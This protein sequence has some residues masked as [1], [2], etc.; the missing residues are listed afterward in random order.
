VL[1]PNKL[2]KKVRKKKEPEKE[3]PHEMSE[4]ELYA[5][6]KRRLNK[7]FI[8][9]L[10][11]DKLKMKITTESNNAT[12]VTTTTT[13]INT[14]NTNQ[15]FNEVMEHTGKGNHRHDFSDAITETTN[16]GGS[17]QE[18]TTNYKDESNWTIDFF[19][20]HT[21]KKFSI[22]T[23]R[24]KTPYNG[25]VLLAR[26]KDFSPA[27]DT[28]EPLHHAAQHHKAQV[29]SYVKR[30]ENVEL[31]QHIQENKMNLFTA[32]IAQEICKDIMTENKSKNT[33]I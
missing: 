2:T 14:P 1:Q 21:K 29:L 11:L 17:E 32:D 15:E 18:V 19:V 25:Y 12:M 6:E 20:N 3:Q 26:W 30:P 13:S 7:E 9:R 8:K 24:K 22:G 27:D 28:E 33:N 23:K 31:L 10:E 5:Q 4:Y 16:I